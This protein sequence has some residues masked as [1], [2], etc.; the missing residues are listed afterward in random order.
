MQLSNQQAESLIRDGVAALQQGRPA[1]AR[2]RFESVTQTAGRAAR[3]GCSSPPPAARKPTSRAKKRRSIGCS[4]WS[5]ARCAA[6][7]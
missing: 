7:S 2:E 3:S 5:R 4:S 1:E 6:T